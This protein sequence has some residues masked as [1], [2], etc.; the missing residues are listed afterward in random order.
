MRKYL[1]IYLFLVPILASAFTGKAQING[2]CYYIITKGN[3]AGV[4]QKQGQR[5]SG[6]IVI[7]S[8]IVYEGVTCN[9]TYIDREAFRFCNLNSVTIPNSVR[10]IGEF[11]FEHCSM[12]KI[13]I[14]GSVK[15]IGDFAFSETQGL[16]SVHITDLAAW[17]RIPFGTGANPLAC[18][19]HLYLN[20]KKVTDLI[21]PMSITTIG[22]NTFEGCSMSSVKFH[23]DVTE[24]GEAAFLGCYN[25]KSVTLPPKVKS[26]DERAFRDCKNLTTV[27]IRQTKECYIGKYAFENCPEL[28]DVY[29]Y[30]NPKFGGDHLKT[31]FYGSNIEYATL[32]VQSPYLFDYSQRVPWSRFKKIVRIE[33][34]PKEYKK[35]VELIEDKYIDPENEYLLK[36]QIKGKGKYYMYIGE[37]Q[38][39][40][41]QGQSSLKR[42]VELLYFLSLDFMG[43]HMFY[44]PYIM[45]EPVLPSGEK[46]NMKP[47]K[48]GTSCQYILYDGFIYIWKK[49]DF[50]DIKMYLQYDSIN[51]RLIRIKDN[52]V[53]IPRFL[54][55]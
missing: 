45:T 21:I 8:K 48:D 1:F 18:A 35:I 36:H 24:I 25:L 16:T 39:V 41:D 54:D 13:N 37:A 5:Y 6:D 52:R 30:F 17:C 26:I 27:T 22:R 32:H 11:A 10:E 38:K 12:T 29:C 31:I 40:E 53:Y 4:I 46:G 55:N 14:P 3:E 49:N 50:S 34:I 51:D 23:N 7:P 33:E 20:G 28:T 15:K 43:N 42:D 9:V 2:I 19:H 47:Q 44:E